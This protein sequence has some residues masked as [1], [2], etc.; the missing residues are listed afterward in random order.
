MGANLKQTHDMMFNNI[1][2]RE[3]FYCL[4]YKKFDTT[5]SSLDVYRIKEK[6]GKFIG[7]YKWHLDA[8]RYDY[9]L[10]NPTNKEIVVDKADRLMSGEYITA[11]VSI[12]AQCSNYKFLRANNSKIRELAIIGDDAVTAVPYDENLRMIERNLQE[13]GSPISEEKSLVG[14]NFATYNRRI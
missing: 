6:F 2:E 12:A 9:P 4:D 14:V 3:V 8:E 10:V 5:I 7:N 11:V 1:G 13:I